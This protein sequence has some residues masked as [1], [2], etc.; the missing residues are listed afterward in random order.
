MNDF[1]ATSVFRYFI[2]PLASVLLGIGIKTASRNDRYVAFRKE[3]IAVGLELMRTACLLFVVLTT[4]KALALVRL[5]RDLND[6]LVAIPSPDMARVRTLQEQAQLLSAKLAGAGWMIL[7][8]FL[9]LWSVST[10]VRK[11]GWRSET[12][13][14]PLLGITLPLVFGIL[15]LVVVMAGASQ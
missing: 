4:D 7:L 5:S 9:S 13:M 6:S 2:F 3:D 12:E 10:I 1:L 11:W 14:A 8:L 15:M